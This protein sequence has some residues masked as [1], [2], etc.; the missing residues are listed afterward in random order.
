VHEKFK[1]SAR[2]AHRF[3]VGAGLFCRDVLPSVNIVKKAGYRDILNC[4]LIKFIY[5]Y[6]KK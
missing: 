4:F 1:K 3:F 6:R 5:I 2:A